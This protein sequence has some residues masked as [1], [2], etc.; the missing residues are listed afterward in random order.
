MIT[1]KDKSMAV[2]C[3]NCPVCS[4]A[5]KKQKGLVFWLVKNIHN[6]CDSSH[7]F[8]YC[9]L[10]DFWQTGRKGFRKMARL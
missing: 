10:F 2:K 5:R 6:W 9:V 1:E 7:H 8:N 3:L 4:Y